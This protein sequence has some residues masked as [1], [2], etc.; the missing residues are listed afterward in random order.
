MGL[1]SIHGKMMLLWLVALRDSSLSVLAQL[2]TAVSCCNK[3]A[4]LAE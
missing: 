2:F 1:V 3:W 4:I